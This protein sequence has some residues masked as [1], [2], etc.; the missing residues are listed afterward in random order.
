MTIEL[1]RTF[2]MWCTVLNV[3]LLTFWTVVWTAFP[4]LVYRIQKRWFPLSR[5]AYDTFMYGFLGFFKIVV[6]VFSLVPWLA[7]VLM[8]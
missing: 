8:G 4:D 5:E 3:G 2:F 7:L 1:L 6:I